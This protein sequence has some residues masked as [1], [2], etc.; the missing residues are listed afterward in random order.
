MSC[1]VLV[2]RLRKCFDPRVPSDLLDHAD[3]VPT[4]IEGLEDPIVDRPGAPAHRAGLVPFPES[5]P[6]VQALIELATRLELAVDIVHQ[7]VTAYVRKAAALE[8]PGGDVCERL[9]EIGAVPEH[10]QEGLNL[11]EDEARD[12]QSRPN[13]AWRQSGLHGLFFSLKIASERT[14][15]GR[16]AI[17]G[18]VDRKTR[19]GGIVQD[20]QIEL[21]AIKGIISEL[22]GEE[23][24][25]RI[26]RALRGEQDLL[27]VL[28]G[29]Q[30][31]AGLLV[32]D[33][34]LN[35]IDPEPGQ[36]DRGD[37]PPVYSLFD[38]FGQIIQ[39]SNGEGQGRVALQQRERNCPE[40][41]HDWLWLLFEAE[42]F[43]H[44]TKRIRT[45]TL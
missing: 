35:G 10:R 18:L 34:P 19:R 32:T 24:I 33:R 17:F 12:A 26:R 14:K 40:I 23:F 16:R 22:Q 44:V 4:S 36:Q 41:G 37:Q 1:A 7:L 30:K 45:L 11:L 31:Y 3:V 43:E 27:A 38:V 28:S 13:L 25:R 15:H 6:I 21:D 39:L 2:R 5:G 9:E 20:D 29:C 42:V 8:D